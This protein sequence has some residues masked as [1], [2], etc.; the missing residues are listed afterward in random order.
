ML[1]IAASAALFGLTPLG[2]RTS[3]RT[4][5]YSV[6]PWLIEVRH[7]EFRKDIEC[8][9]VNDFGNFPDIIADRHVIQIRLPH[10]TDGAQAWFKVDNEAARPW[11]DVEAA[12]IADGATAEAETLDNATGGQL[13]LPYSAIN[14]AERISIQLKAPG[15]VLNCK[16]RSDLTFPD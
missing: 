8:R 1:L 9:L 2:H 10:Q 16:R 3:S 4:S 7:D 13:P 6:G 11:R 15:P 5:A 12:L 14:H